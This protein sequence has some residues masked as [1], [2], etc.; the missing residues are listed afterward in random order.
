MKLMLTMTLGVLEGQREDQLDALLTLGVG[1][2][3][4]CLRL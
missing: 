2:R 4:A 1:R 3:W